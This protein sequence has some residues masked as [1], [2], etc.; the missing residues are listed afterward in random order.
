MINLNSGSIGAL[1][2][3]G[4]AC[5]IALYVIGFTEVLTGTTA[6]S[7]P[8]SIVGTIDPDNTFFGIVDVVTGWFGLTGGQTL[9]DMRIYSLI[10]ICFL[11]CM[12]LIGVGWVINAPGNNFYKSHFDILY[13]LHRRG[14]RQI[15][16][17]C[18]V[19]RGIAR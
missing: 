15:R 12:A 9:N 6:L 13:L 5:A 3:V 16:Q 1:F 4:L 8:F 17:N 19:K 2:F 18:K 7:I 10:L 14:Y 11:L